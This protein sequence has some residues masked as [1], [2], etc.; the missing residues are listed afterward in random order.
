MYGTV[1]I[2]TTYGDFEGIIVGVIGVDTDGKYFPGN[3]YEPPEYK[4]LVFDKMIIECFDLREKDAD[5]IK[6]IEIC[7]LEVR[8]LVDED[9]VEYGTDLDLDNWYY[10]NESSCLVLECI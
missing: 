8:L 1:T 9:T 4:E 6:S 10:D 2:K 5:S 7:E 3:Y